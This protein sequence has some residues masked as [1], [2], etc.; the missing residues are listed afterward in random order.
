MLSFIKN[1]FEDKTTKKSGEVEKKVE[2]KS[3]LTKR[4]YV[5]LK[6]DFEEEELE[7]IKEKLMIKPVENPD[8]KFD[9]KV[10]L[11]KVFQENV[12]KLYLPKM[13]A[14]EKL[15]KPTIDKTPPGTDIEFE[16]LI[17]LRPYQE[18]AASVSLDLLRKKGG[19][20]LSLPCGRGKTIVALH[21]AAELSKKVLI[22][23]HKDFL[24]QQWLD[25]ILG[26][27]EKGVPAKFKDSSVGIIK[28][29]IFDI[30]DKQFVIAT[31]QSV[32]MKNF[33]LAAFD[34]FGLVIL[35]EAHLV[36][37]K[38]FSK[39]LQKVNST[40]M[41]GLTATPRRKD[42]LFKILK[43]YVGDIMYK[44]KP[45]K[46]HEVAVRRY[47]FTSVDPE[48]CQEVV[49]HMRSRTIVNRA[50][51][52]ENVVTCLARNR[53]ITKTIAWLFEKG[54]KKIL[55]LSERIAH[56]DLM[57]EI[58]D[59]YESGKSCS[60]YTGKVKKKLLPE[61]EKADCIFGTYSMAA[62]GMDIPDLDAMILA[63]PMSDIEQAVGRILRK[64]SDYDKLVI[65]IVDSFSIF[66]G[67]ARKRMQFF[68][69]KKYNVVDYAVDEK[70]VAEEGKSYI[71]SDGEE[72]QPKVDESCLALEAPKYKKMVFKSNPFL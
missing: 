43:M 33:P 39:A 2:K 1:E 42:G 30:V 45:I 50:K 13:W 6:E 23:V 38:V 41:L 26:N 36:P 71:F 25:H 69:K 52:I 34:S 57:K 9:D 65:D 63:S 72:V 47:I 48:Y 20:V 14:I 8:Y 58:F 28:G 7:K 22:I 21:I 46:V 44:E 17:K 10:T 27:D 35:D 15:G 56:L 61:A 40:Y 32:S 59:S 31:I 55:V 37:C 53:V 4:G 3:Y 62:V 5:I 70:G 60:F 66:T 16:S 19:G 29:N 68:K 12:N 11:I 24:V 54:Y 51:M 64:K 49:T 67:Q 18:L